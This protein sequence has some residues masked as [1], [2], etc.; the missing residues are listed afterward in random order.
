[1][2]QAPYQLK[3][4]KRIPYNVNKFTSSK[5][6]RLSECMQSGQVHLGEVPKIKKCLK[7]GVYVFLGSFL[8]LAKDAL[9]CENYFN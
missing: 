2:K 7:N 3:V 6:L 8:N 1:M 5:N 4:L 9:T